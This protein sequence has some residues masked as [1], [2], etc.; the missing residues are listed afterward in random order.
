M[1]VALIDVLRV[2]TLV[3]GVIITAG[4]YAQT[5]KIFQTK[6]AKDFTILL[7]VS[8]F[9]NE[10]SWLAYGSGLREWPIIVLCLANLP[11]EVMML[12]GY[13]KYRG[14]QDDHSLPKN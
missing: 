2:N 5:I 1:Y 11:A 12:I 3:A 7:I 9:Y 10:L 14:G 4:F 8:L 13:L 6:S